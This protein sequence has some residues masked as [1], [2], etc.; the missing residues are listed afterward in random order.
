MG[1]VEK[2]KNIIK[3]AEGEPSRVNLLKPRENK[4]KKKFSVKIYNKKFDKEYILETD[5]TLYDLQ[6]DWDKSNDED[7]EILEH[8]AIVWMSF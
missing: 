8:K 5:K 1:I 2:I 3:P 7:H 6:A 4:L